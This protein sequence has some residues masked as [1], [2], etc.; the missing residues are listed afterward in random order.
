MVSP[1]NFHPFG[2]KSITMPCKWHRLQNKKKSCKLVHIFRSIPLATETQ[3]VFRC[4][5]KRK[6]CEWTDCKTLIHL[7]A[8]LGSQLRPPLKPIEHH[9]FPIV[10][11]DL[12]GTLTHY[13]P[14][15]PRDVSASGSRYDFPH[16]G[17]LFEIRL[18]LPFSN[19]FGT[20][21]KHCPF[22]VLNQSMH[23]K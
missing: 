16:V 4:K 17:N 3:T 7:S 18:Y 14:M 11:G 22:T 13:N 12:Q 1:F 5:R 9:G 10:S 23:G 20:A 8:S 15:I 6:F 19:S 21:N 2:T